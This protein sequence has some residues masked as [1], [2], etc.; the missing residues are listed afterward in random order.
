MD[1]E[2]VFDCPESIGDC[3]IVYLNQKQPNFTV[4]LFYFL[5]NTVRNSAPANVRPL[6][7]P[8]G[9]VDRRNS[10]GN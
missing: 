3:I 2:Y 6:G 7:R 10:I 5:R 1:S 8:L 9:T 4:F